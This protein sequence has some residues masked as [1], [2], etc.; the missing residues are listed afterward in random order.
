MRKLLSIFAVLGVILSSFS[1]KDQELFRINDTKIML[2]EFKQMYEKNLS[3]VE[4]KNG[5]DVDS[6]LDLFI[7]YKLKVKEAY[8]LGLDKNEA[9][10]KEFES[11]KKE[12]VTP[13]LYDKK[14]LEKLVR[15]AY[16]RKKKTK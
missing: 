4:D 10:K 11:Y 2:S 15:E 13:Y 14:A 6:Y 8:S 12:L 16:D 5:A 7:N 3:L 1:Q 9:Y